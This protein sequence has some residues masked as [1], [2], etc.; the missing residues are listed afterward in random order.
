MQIFF[1]R[2]IDIRIGI[3][4]KTCALAALC[5]LSCNDSYDNHNLRIEVSNW[6]D[7]DRKE[8]VSIDRSE[9][10]DFVEEGS[11]VDLR[12]RKEDGEDYFRTQW[13]DY[14]ED[15]ELDELLFQA[16][17]PAKATAEYEVVIDSTIAEPE[18]NVVAYSRFV[19][20]RT[21]DY[22][23]EN[24]KV[25]FR[26]YGPTGEKEALEGVEGST[27]SSGIDLWLK[28]TDESVIDKWYREHQKSPGYYHK[29]HG[30]GYDPYHVGASRGTGGSG[31]WVD[32]SLQVSRNFTD[33]KTIADGPLR[34]VF[35]LIYAAPWSEFG[36]TETKR[37]SLDLGSHFS[38]F[39][40]SI[41]SEEEIPN[42]AVGISL[43]Y[44][45]G[46]AE[47][48]EEEGWVKH[49]E[50]IDGSYVGEAL[51]LDPGV[52]DSAFVY[53]TEMPD[54]SNLLVLTDP[55]NEKL[56]YYV[57]FVWEKAEEITKEQEWKT[58]IEDFS[59]TINE[60]LEVKIVK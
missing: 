2:I 50:T 25:A 40:V 59:T 15:G 43:H 4:R 46:E 60:P 31:I 26:T 58:H 51:V 27:L 54:Q 6:L 33:Y 39:E 38:K 53:R 34:T 9:L 11:E 23:W 35:E 48:N 22:T 7:F 18:S 44:N 17:V 49:W 3:F 24:D 28:R 20:E 55:E 29:D 36:V 5:F 19:P 37:I 16:V 47:I 1:Y 14:D 30:E 56:T 32:D 57:G 45:E 12:I 8:V 10:S 13:I 21:D 52:I 41:D 42:Y